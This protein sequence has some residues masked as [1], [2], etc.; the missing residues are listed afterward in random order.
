ME[1]DHFRDMIRLALIG[2]L[3]N[4]WPQFESYVR[5]TVSLIPNSL[6]RLQ[7]VNPQLHTDASKSP[8][9]RDE[10][11]WRKFQSAHQGLAL[12]MM[13][14]LLGS[15]SAN[16]DT[17]DR[18]M[19]M[20]VEYPGRIPLPELRNVVRDLILS[21]GMNP[22]G[23]SYRLLQY[24]VEREYHD[25]YKCYNW[26]GGSPQ[27]RTDLVQQAIRLLGQ[28]DASLMSE[29]MYALF[30]HVA[31]TLESLGQGWVTYQL[32]GNPTDQVVQATDAV[33]RLLELAVLIAMQNTLN[34]VIQM[35]YPPSLVATL[36]I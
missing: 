33:I 13:N 12:E 7:A 18:L 25:W 24:R 21:L 1:R 28:I 35:S 3:N 29:L 11:L 5:R 36:L 4:Y 23:T 30:P 32:Y 2:A 31:R 16:Q 34:Q 20:I 15:P 9:S 27:E 8:Q 14:W 22:G 6:E 10:E 17:L 26:Q 19:N